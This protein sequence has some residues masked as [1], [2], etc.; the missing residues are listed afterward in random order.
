MMKGLLIAAIFAAAMSTIAT[1]LNSSATLLVTDWYQR[2]IRPQASEKQCMSALYLLTIVWG[3]LG[4]GIALLLIRVTSALDVWW[5]LSGI[6]GGGVLGLFLLGFISRKA[7]NPIAVT[8]VLLGLLVI[9]WLTL[10][11]QIKSWP[12][13]LQ[14]HC[15]AFLIPVAGTLT[16]LL[17]GLCLQAILKLKRKTDSAPEHT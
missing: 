8:A 16:I 12:K 11:G 9:S 14:N 7:G 13:A 17:A 5:M 2:F 4:T 1:S 3:L 10:S 15:H 6:L